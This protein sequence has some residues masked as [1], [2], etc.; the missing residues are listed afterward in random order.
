MATPHRFV[1]TGGQALDAKNRLAFRDNRA[2]RD[3]RRRNS[4][5]NLI[6]LLAMISCSQSPVAPQGNVAGDG[7]VVSPP[8]DTTWDGVLEIN[9][10]SF[11]STDELRADRRTFPTGN[12]NV[13]HVHLDK[14]VAFTEAGLTRS[15]RYDWV[16]QGTKSVSIGRGIELPVRVKE[17]WTE[18]VIRWSPNFTP[19]HPQDP[20]CDHKTL[21]Y[22]VTP[23]G[24]YRWSVHVG[25]GAGEGGPNA[26]VTIFT[27]KGHLEGTDSNGGWGLPAIARSHKSIEMVN[28]NQYYDGKWHI[29]RLHAKH[30]TD[31]RTHDGRMRLWI[32]GE[33]LY[34]TEKMR[35]E[36]GA[37]GF[38]T[39]DG[40][41][42]RAILLGRN[43]DKGLDKGTES[44]WI[45]RVRAYKTDPGW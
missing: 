41:V 12:L 9:L 5:I 8:S 24:N 21:F 19:C 43:K 42:I 18:V 1:R 16:D 37:P 4:M 13:D 15:M 44:M 23:D 32:D 30:S 40:T 10:E 3:K 31:G 27:P 6:L 7:G 39:E 38:A 28:A 11:S 35:Q 22:Q 17:L 33:L 25:G 29:L 26:H 34:D 20:P 2:V 14:S 45:G 36:H